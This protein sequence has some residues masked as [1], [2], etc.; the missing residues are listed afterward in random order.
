VD[1]SGK[2]AFVTGGGR[3]IGRVIAIPLAETGAYV[4]VN[5]KENKSAAGE[6]ISAISRPEQVAAVAVMLG[7]YGY[8]TGQSINIDGGLYPTS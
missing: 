1:I 6:L 5:Y 7:R 2:V 4:A 3:G 8:L